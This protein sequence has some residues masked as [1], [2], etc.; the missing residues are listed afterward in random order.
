M[1]V[2]PPDVCVALQRTDHSLC[3]IL[4]SLPATVMRV[5]LA[6]EIE[7]VNRVLPGS[8]DPVGQS[9]FS[10]AP[11]EQH[12]AI[13][14]ALERTRA[15]L[16]PT[17][18]E[19]FVLT[20]DGKRDWRVTT[21]GPILRG[22][23]VVGFTLVTVGDSRIFRAEDAL[24]ESRA[25]LKLA[26]DAGNVG[27]WRWDRLRDLVEWDDKL[28]AMWGV[29][30][31]RAPRN[32]AEFMALV[33]EVHR[34]AMGA[35]IGRA[36]ETG[37]YPDYELETETPAGPRVFII[38]GGMLRGAAG[39]IVG[40]LG[41]VVDV[42]EQRLMHEH[43]RVAQKLEAVGQLSAGVAHN[44]NNM[45]AVIVPALELAKLASTT[46]IDAQL[47]DDALTSAT[48]AA[49]LVRQ[50]MV[51]S[52]RHPAVG[53]RHEALADVVRR[54]V[55]LCRQTFERRVTLQLGDLEAARFAGVEPGP[56][57][58]AVMN[59]LLNARDAVM[60][61]LARPARIEVSARRVAEAE[62]TRRQS[63]AQGAYVELRVQDTG[64]GMDATTRRRMLEP[65]FTTK[66]M[67]RGT[68]LGLATA[69]ATVKAHHGFLECES[70][71][72]E[73]TTFSLLLPAGE[74]EVARV[75]L[76]QPAGAT[77]GAGRV[78]L[79]ID[80][81]EAVSRANAAVLRAAGFKV[82]LAS[83]GE[84]ALRLAAGH[85]IDAV[86]LDYSMPGLSAQ[87]T[88]AGLRRG[89]PGLPVVCLS[90]LGTTLEGATSQLVKP[91]SRG[92]L[93]RAIEDALALSPA[94]R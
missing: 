4:E 67:G 22:D 23:L 52:G 71:P 58:Q 54:A 45:L 33:P 5:S 91:A 59:L 10:L 79:L 65:F 69:W 94:S 70:E 81:E 34:P 27:V 32:V 21:V 18:W 42:T 50:L 82:L 60:I 92:E 53:A 57:E 62:A 86:V 17:S 30:P 36:L 76:S 37:V 49:Q 44:F 1:A 7:F 38:K 24:V 83:S 28:S 29:T 43:L 66:P 13:R 64:C 40:L 74:A 47:L 39:E 12:E 56:M 77:R 6:G 31:E 73:G 78:V 41:G 89:R 25:R 87:D 68:G 55:E 63:E 20:P 85:T 2:L 93:V 9:L 15:Q 88:L 35:H 90:G 51:F 80:D 3:S 61:D 75:P 16:Q 19:S 11:P 8:E 26:L 48:N 46:G 84:L 72:Q 14:S